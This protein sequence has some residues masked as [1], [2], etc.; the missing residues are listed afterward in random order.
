MPTSYTPAVTTPPMYA[1]SYTSTQPLPQS[2]A[3]G[4]TPATGYSTGYYTTGVNPQMSQA[5]SASS[6][7]AVCQASPALTSMA[8]PP[9]SL[10]TQVVGS[11]SYP[12][13]S[14]TMAHSSYYPTYMASEV[15]ASTSYSMEDAS[16]VMAS[17]SYMPVEQDIFMEP[18]PLEASSLSLPDPEFRR[19]VPP[20]G[21]TPTP[22]ASSTPA[23]STTGAG[24]THLPGPASSASD[25][26]RAAGTAS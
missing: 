8:Y 1:T 15:T 9:L 24:S 2:A 16:Q 5:V 21:G 7:L 14:Y 4:V 20:Q 12:Q 6:S 13:V 25:S 10:T 3:Y 22:A 17:V 18:T 26:L 23:V 19:P 11:P